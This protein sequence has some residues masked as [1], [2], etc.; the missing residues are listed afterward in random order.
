M[1]LSDLATVIEYDVKKPAFSGQNLRWVS[2]DNHYYSGLD[3]LQV[4]RRMSRILSL[5]IPAGLSMKI[6]SI[7]C[8]RATSFSWG[9]PLAVVGASGC[10]KS[11]VV[12]V[13]P[14]DIPAEGRG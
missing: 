9:R 13:G 4:S 1:I 3:S 8:L 10:G 2:R 6:F 14:G 5:M 12:R 7:H 11:S